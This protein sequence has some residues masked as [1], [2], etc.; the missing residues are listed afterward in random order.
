MTM[1]PASPPR[2]RAIVAIIVI[3]SLG[4]I[5]GSAVTAIIG[6]RLFKRAVMAPAHPPGPQAGPNLADRATKRITA[7]LASQ[8]DLTPEQTQQVAFELDR[9][10]EA[11]RR[12][13]ADMIRDTRKELFVAIRR[14]SV[15]LPQEKRAEFRRLI[16][17]R[18]DR[19]G[20][21]P[22]PENEEP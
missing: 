3:F 16:R 15:N 14:I 18:F 13:R 10:T 1:N 20:L 8:L 19:A 21:P 2:W 12:A 6:A 4:I 22:P 17:K 7:D 5:V 9:M 11:M